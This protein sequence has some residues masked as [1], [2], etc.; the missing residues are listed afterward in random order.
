MIN[1]KMSSHMVLDA[2]FQALIDKVTIAG[3]AGSGL[4]LFVMDNNEYL[5]IIPAALV[6]T[7]AFWKHFQSARKASIEAN[8]SKKDSQIKDELLEKA[9]LEKEIV[10]EMLEQERIK[11]HRLKSE[12]NI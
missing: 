4:M 7:A 11:T 5:A 6:A 2:A 10:Q 9:Q 1:A 12:N 8:N 3:L